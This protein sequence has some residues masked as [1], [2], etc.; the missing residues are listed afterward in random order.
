MTTMQNKI[1]ELFQINIRRRSPKGWY[2]GNCPFCGK[3]A[4]LG[5]NLGELSEGKYKDKISF[6]CVKCSEK[7]GLFKLLKK[8]GKDDLLAGYE[9]V[10]AS[11]PVEKKIGV[12]KGVEEDLEVPVKTPPLGWRRI[13]DNDYLNER[14][15]EP[16]QYDSFKVGMTKLFPRLKGYL[17]FLIEEDGENKGYIARSTKGKEWIT[18]FNDKIKEYNK[19]ADKDYRK[20]KYLRYQNEGG[21]AF[22]K[23]LFGLDEVTEKTHTVI[24]V[25]GIT[26]KANVDRKL[27]LNLSDDIKCLVSF[28]KALGDTQIIKLKKKGSNINSVILLY[29]PDA[30]NDSKEYGSKLEAEFKSTKIGFLKDKDPGDLSL[31]EMLDVLD[32]LESPINFSTGKVQKKNLFI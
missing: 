18:E 14:G 17:I 25:E 6:R 2:E 4:H 15:F 12:T 1:V 19:T 32:N 10:D 21:V 24:I 13:S 26:D 22:E 11:L 29:D 3:E 16:W 23:L 31:E 27:R 8:I 28:G 20:N 9:S 7:G 30:I 5:I